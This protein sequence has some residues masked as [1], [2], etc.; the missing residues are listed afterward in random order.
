VM[1]YHVGGGG[2]FYFQSE[3]DGAPVKC[4]SSSVSIRAS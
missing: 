4:M 1:M 2:V 3:P